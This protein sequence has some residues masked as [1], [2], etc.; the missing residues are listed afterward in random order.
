MSYSVIGIIAILLHL[1]INRD[2]LWGKSTANNIPAYREYRFFIIGILIFCVTDV[3]WGIFNEYHLI[4]PLYAVTVAYFVTMMIG[5]L[6]W[7]KYV[8]S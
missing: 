8:V 2:V 1:I 4:T 5:F 7:T 3:L 6:A